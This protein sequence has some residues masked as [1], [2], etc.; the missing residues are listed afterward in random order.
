M[1]SRGPYPGSSR[2]LVLAFDVG[3]TFSGVS[4]S[5]LDPGNVPEIK[6]LTRFPYQDS[7]GGD[8]KVPSIIWYDTN[9]KVR[10]IGAGAVQD[11]IEQEAEDGEWTKVEWFKLHLRPKTLGADDVSKFAQQMPSLPACK[12]I[13]DVFADYYQ[14][15]YESSKAYIESNY[16]TGERIWA[17]T[18]SNIVFVLSHPNG[19]E[20]PQQ[21]Q[22]R[23]AAIFAGLVP[24]TDEGRNRIHFV[25]EGE[26]SLHFCINQG[27]MTERIKND[28]R[29]LVV[30]AGGGTIDISSYEKQEDEDR[31]FS[32]L[33]VPECKLRGSIFVTQYARKYLEGVEEYL[34]DSPFSSAASDIARCFDKSTKLH[35]R[36][37]E[38]PAFIK[39]GTFRDSDPA[40]NIRSG[41]LKLQGD[42]V[43]T[44][45]QSSVDCIVD[46]ILK[47]CRDY[48]TKSVFLVGGFA[49]SDWLF[50]NVKTATL[51][52]NIEVS[53]PQTQTNK[54][55]ADGATSFY[56]DHFVSTRI[57]KF[58]YGIRTK[59]RYNASQKDHVAR[60]GESY[61]DVDGKTRISGGFDI[62]LPKSSTVNETKEFCKT[63]DHIKRDHVALQ[64]IKIVLLRYRGSLDHPNWMDEDP[65][66]FNPP[67]PLPL[68]H[69]SQ[70]TLNAALLSQRKL[71][72]TYFELTFG[73]VLL[74]GLTEFKA[75]LSWKENGVEKR[76]LNP[77]VVPEIKEMT[78]FPY[79]DS[80]KG[81]C[82]V[83]SIIWYDIDGKVCAIGAGAVRDGIEEDAE[84]GEWTKVEWF[85]LHLR[86]KTLDA[87]EV[88]KFSQ[89][90]PPLPDGKTI[91][92]VFADY[93]RFLHESSKNYIES[94]YSTGKSIWAFVE[95][96]TVFVLSHPNGWEGPQ[97]SQMR[98]AAIL[99][100]LV[101]DT[102]DGRNRI[103]FVTEGE[104][105]LHFCINQGLMTEKIKL[106]ASMINTHAGGGT[107]DISSYEKEK[108]KE[109]SFSELAAPECKLRGSIFVTQHARKYLEEHLRDSS[110]FTD[111]LEI[112]RCFDKSTKIHF[113]NIQDPA[114]I[115]FG[116][117][118]D[119]DPTHNIRRGQLKLP[120]SGTMTLS[121]IDCIVDVIRKQCGDYNI[122]TVFLV[123]GFAAS[124]WLFNSVQAAV[125]S[126]NVEISRPVGQ[127]SKAVAIGVASFYMD[128]FVLIRTSKFDYGVDCNRMY[129]AHK[130]DHVAREAARYVDLAGEEVLQNAFDI[131]LPKN[132]RITEETE[133]K[134]SFYS[135]STY[136]DPLR[137]VTTKVFRYRGTLECPQWV[138]EDPD[139]FEVMCT[140]EADTSAATAA[141]S[142]WRGRNGQSYFRLDYDIVLL[143]GL[144]EFKAQI[145]WRENGLEKRGLARMVYEP[146]KPP[147]STP[148][149][150]LPRQPHTGNSRRLVLA[151]DVGTTFSSVSYSILD[152]GC[153]PEIKGI[154]RFPCH[155]STT[156]DSKV[157]S[158][159]WYDTN[160]LVR[161]IGF[162]DKIEQEAVDE[163]WTKI[164]WFN[165]YLGPSSGEVS[166]FAQQV[167]P[168]PNGKTVVD[169]L[170]DYYRFL[171]ESSRDFI[172]S[173]HPAGKI[174]WASMQSNTIFV[175][176]HPNGWAGHHQSQMRQAAGRAG[177]ISDD[178]E[179]RNRIHFVTEG[180]ASLHF[181]INQGLMTEVA[182]TGS[183][184]LV[185]DAGHRTIDISSHEKREG[186]FSKLA[187]PECRLHGSIFVTQYARKYIEGDRLSPS[188][189]FYALTRPI[190]EYLRDSRFSPD[191]PD[192]IRCFD[193]T[194]MLRFRQKEEPAFIKFG[195]SRDND[196][197]HNIKCGQLKIQGYIIATFFQPS[198][199]CIVDTI[200]KHFRSHNIRAVF[201]V[202]SFATN[203]WLF[204][205]VQAAVLDLNINIEISRPYAHTG[206][207]VG[208]G[209]VAYYI[210]RFVLKD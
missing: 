188:A 176:S 184:F 115:K 202:G 194:T 2:R 59:V 58:H 163:Q 14:F 187:A 135:L 116:L 41:H 15:L 168:L 69:V 125:R 195:S 73:I 23:E 66:M 167:S 118:R 203:D 88:S 151:F 189:V 111:V 21:S 91:V 96:T 117:A 103:H 13:V 170:A 145:A 108:D 153:V 157:P 34:R 129:D 56:I 173:H 87:D 76:I 95:L 180:E 113:R 181:C 206:M 8:F 90:I 134:H 207:L 49:A 107:I 110:F 100:G 54:A 208:S 122:K 143:F 80:T 6:G 127:T 39:F 52:M 139:M 178:D 42:I 133:F 150:K 204:R 192:I 198:V 177:L 169:V 199:D 55:V 57:A 148:A 200:R 130:A 94:H 86:P 10:A 72:H 79:H 210:D 17:S 37:K 128:H 154:T 160:G 22:M 12:T 132:A 47:H 38:D 147:S 155:N 109:G 105:S 36:R 43:A 27:V 61:I 140:I 48:K 104:A 35:F 24:D 30:D 164:E 152:P 50:E 159:I 44:F 98:E 28:S 137:S 126:M 62:I 166:R 85:K 114:T 5:I 25:T 172:E 11:G 193:K 106:S 112:S 53:R 161:A 71:G 92:D 121:S 197:A 144:A 45:F 65:G 146:I 82:K 93:Y 119:S 64:S 175:L 205:S 18:Q 190:Q 74:F 186:S 209:A 75:Q 68:L 201:L 9:G 101:P 165:L 7:T 124:D 158:I 31:S 29:V 185:V 46:T 3:T 179:G 141:L 1:S 84:D 63:F 136:S 60:R 20:G 138:D 191:V 149:T 40:H 182:E 162:P 142:P 196:P 120:G 183:R 99:A 78:E 67:A 77:G 89:R 19:W 97:Q 174:L 123:G 32:E 156:R 4:Y 102:E 16:S 131:I 33:T 171:Y 83:P 70:I 81:D 51:G 26:A